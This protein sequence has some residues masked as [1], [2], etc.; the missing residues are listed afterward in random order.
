MDDIITNQSMKFSSSAYAILLFNF[1]KSSLPCG[2]LFIFFVSLVFC[3]R[4]S[5][6]YFNL[7]TAC[8]VLNYLFVCSD[9]CCLIVAEAL[10]ESS[11]E[12]LPAATGKL[13]M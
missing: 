2:T 6:Q 12:P 11:E 9:S 8:V 10:A 13:Q 5:L 4:S 3:V 1:K 7:L